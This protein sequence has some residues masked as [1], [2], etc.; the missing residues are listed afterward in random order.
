MVKVSEFRNRGGSTSWR[1][2]WKDPDPAIQKR[3]RENFSDAE[4][5]Y[6]RKGELEM[7]LSGVTSSSSL[8]KTRLSEI[9][10]A[11]AEAAK[12]LAGDRTLTGIT[13][14]YLE[15][16]STL[17][18]LST[19]FRTAIQFLTQ[20]FR[21]EI[22]SITV[23]EAC[24]QFLESRR[25]LQ[26]AEK[27]LDYYHETANRILQLGPDRQLSGIIITDIEQILKQYTN[28][29][30]KKT[31]RR[32]INV[33]F[34]WA[35]RHHYILKNPCERL[36]KIPQDMSK[37]VI[38]DLASCQRLLRAAMDFQSGKMAG[39]IAVLL[40]AGLRL[41]ELN[42]LKPKD[43]REDKIRIDGGKKKRTLK[44]VTPIPPNLREWLQ[45]YPFTGIPEGWVYAWRK[46][47]KASGAADWVNDI[48]RHTS[49]SY[50]IERD[51][52]IDKV[53]LDC[54]TSPAMIDLHYR[55]II[56]SP[57]DVEAFWNITPSTLN[58]ILPES[59][60]QEPKRVIWPNNKKFA[61]ML[62]TQSLV[63]IGR[64]IGVSDN[65]VR[66]HAKKLGLLPTTGVTS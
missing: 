30:S 57:E 14:K 32:G 35:L 4:D 29:N 49:I 43:I 59:V 10:I 27:T 63:S 2:T 31:V 64:E 62:K 25:Q 12:A 51:K 5:A 44:R 23:R 36:D 18:S 50:Q 45:V 37:I 13:Q 22:Q 28:L 48:L 17:K 26:L 3:H 19:D 21:N 47:K 38:L 66:K 54:G 52:S 24:E 9:V 8:V 40:F 20:H 55:Q 39:P 34:S 33:F 15:L 53:A 11:D 46:L 65:A 60:I 42:D 61:R 1:V 7:Q 56:E 6:A 16:E 58:E 41:G